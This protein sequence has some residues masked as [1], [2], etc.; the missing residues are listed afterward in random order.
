MNQVILIIRSLSKKIEIELYFLFFLILIAAVLEVLG[1]SLIIPLIDAVLNKDHK[2]IAFISDRFNFDNIEIILLLIFILFYFLKTLFLIFLSYRKSFL[3]ANIQK[4]I[5]KNL[6]EGYIQQDYQDHQDSKSSEQIRNIVQEATLFSQV[7]GAYLLLATE[8]FVLLAIITFLIFY[9]L[10]ATLII[11]ITTSIVALVIFYLPNKRLK[12]WGKKR[13]YHDD[14]KIKFIQDAFGSFKDIKIRSLENFF[15]SNFFSHNSKSANFIAKMVFVGQIPR[16]FLE[17]F[18][19]LCIC[20]FTVLLLFLNKDYSEILPLIIIFTIAG[21]RLLPSFTKLIAGLQ[22]IKF[23]S[24]V[25]KLIHHELVICKNNKKKEKKDTKIIF[26]DILEVSNLSFKYND[27]H[28]EI[29]KNINFKIKFGEVV[30][31]IGLSG[32]GKSTLVSLITGL[33]IPSKGNIIVDK[34]NINRNFY[35]WYQNIGYIPQNIYLSDDTIKNNIAYGIEPSEINEASIEY[36]IEKSNLKFFIE[37]LDKGIDTAVGELGNK[38]SGGQKQRI[39]IARALYNRPKLLIL[40]EATNSLDQET[41]NKILEELK[42]LKGKITIL[43]ITHRLS[44]LSFCNKI[45]RIKNNHLIQEI[46][47]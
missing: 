13:Q 44:T 21:I 11:F 1:L 27:G 25:V 7:V 22:K 45:F 36:A 4:F 32:A 41:E 28:T 3:A 34:K 20:G 9:N 31:I 23:S 38:I 30:G 26:N 40:D 18:G 16:L 39:G 37:S 47:D 42:I 8:C 15:I 24:V 19:V 33:N 17:F 2:F 46:K 12:F 43:F 6:Y 5:S 14:K 35:S 10:K 29:L